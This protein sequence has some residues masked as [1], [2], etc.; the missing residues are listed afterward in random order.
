MET[1]SIPPQINIL[2]CSGWDDYMLLDSGNGYRLERFGH[3]VLVRP[4]A[5]AIWKPALSEKQWQDFHARFQPSAEEM[6]GHWQIHKAI[7]SPWILSYNKIKFLCQLSGSKQIG[8]F[9]EQ[10]IQ[11]EWISNQLTKTNRPL[12]ILN[13]FGYTGIAS[14]CAI[15]PNSKVTH[16]DASKKVVSWAKENQALSGLQSMPIRWIVDDVIKFVQREVRR[17]VKYDGIILDPPKFGRGPKGEVWEFYKLIPNLLSTIQQVLSSN[18]EF[19]VLTAYAVKASALTLHMALDEMMTSFAG[20]TE[21]GEVVLKDNS[22]GH[23][24]STS[25]FGRW[26]RTNDTHH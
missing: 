13:L 17:G 10:S 5:E 25:I 14:L 1:K 23:L 6:G 18:P 26:S 9:P 19:M 20:Q 4:D 2:T 24:L 16:V 15:A 3:I 8:V 11:W 21:C 7:P 22:V 12:H